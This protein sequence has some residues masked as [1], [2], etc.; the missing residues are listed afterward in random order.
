MR[1]PIRLLA[2]AL[3]GVAA[4]LP[5]PAA[6]ATPSI[7]I[8]PTA[9]GCAIGG[10]VFTTPPLGA[11]PAA[12]SYQVTGTFVC[13]TTPLTVANF[14]VSMSCAADTLATCLSGFAG[15]ATV[16]YS[17]GQ[18]TSCALSPAHITIFYDLDCTMTSSAPS[19]AYELNG[20]LVFEPVGLRTDEFTIAGFLELGG[21]AT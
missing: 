19:S 7:G 21:V 14:S 12:T 8:S 4:V 16:V 11:V 6:A 17:N 13:E 3:L 10:T 20:S 5:R 2:A 15:A 9:G 1:R 18:E